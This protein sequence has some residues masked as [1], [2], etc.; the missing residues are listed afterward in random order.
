MKTSPII[1]EGI[2]EDGGKEKGN[3]IKDADDSRGC[4]PDIM[5]NMIL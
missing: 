3:A 1:T 4:I 2:E 5:L